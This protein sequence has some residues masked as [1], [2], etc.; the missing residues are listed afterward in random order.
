[1][2]PVVI[3]DSAPVSETE[4]PAE[5]VLLASCWEDSGKAVASEVSTEDAVVVSAVMLVMELS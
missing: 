5:K 1:M 2:L 4:D 3:E